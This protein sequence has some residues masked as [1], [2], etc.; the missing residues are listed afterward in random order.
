MI[1]RHW[2]T[3]PAAP[4][5]IQPIA[6]HMRRHLESADRLFM[7]ETTAPVLDS[8]RGQTKKGYFWAIVSD[9]RGDSGPS[10]PIVL[11]R[12]A[13]GRSAPSPSSSWMALT[14]GSCNAMPMTVITG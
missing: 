11:F 12:Y 8:G 10:P 13:L 1:W 4:A 6:D 7:D 14:D 9:D 2:A 5:S 3:G